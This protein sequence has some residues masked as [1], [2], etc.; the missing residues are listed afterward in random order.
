MESSEGFLQSPLSLLYWLMIKVAIVS[1]VEV[2]LWYPLNKAD[3]A[4]AT[5]VSLMF[6]QQRPTWS[7]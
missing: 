5:A 4:T 7:I 1:V 2:L 6:Q 3:L